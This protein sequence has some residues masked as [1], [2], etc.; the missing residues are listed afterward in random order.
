MGKDWRQEPTKRNKLCAQ[1]D[2]RPPPRAR[3]V[4][5]PMEMRPGSQTSHPFSVRGRGKIWSRA[6][7]VA[8]A[9]TAAR[10]F[11]K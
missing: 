3:P 10:A 7:A 5:V 1:T 11:P 6:A 4:S 2:K 9:A 8:R